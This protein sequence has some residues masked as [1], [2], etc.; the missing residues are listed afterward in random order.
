MREYW[1]EF[2]FWRWWW[3]ERVLGFWGWWWRE[4]VTANAKFL[5][6]LVAAALVFGGGLSV[7]WTLPGGDSAGSEAYV[8]PSGEQ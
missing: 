8:P 4:R 5:V 2:G 6:S 7:A 3:R 1:R